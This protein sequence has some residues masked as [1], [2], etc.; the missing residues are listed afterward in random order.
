MLGHEKD[1]QLTAP[2]AK[3]KEVG[4]GRRAVAK[5]DWR[6]EFYAIRNNK[7]SLRVIPNEL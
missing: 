7:L 1:K 6:H 2:K 4:S 3:T 5:R